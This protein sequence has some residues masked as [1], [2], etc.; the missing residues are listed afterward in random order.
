MHWV[1][2]LE[3][4]LM[5]YCLQK[6]GKWWANHF[7]RNKEVSELYA[8]LRRLSADEVRKIL[9]HDEYQRG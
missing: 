5:D 1:Y 8:R 4:E 2:D 9:Y 7:F 3:Q 6:K